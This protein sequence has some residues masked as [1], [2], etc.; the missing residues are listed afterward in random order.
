MILIIN[1]ILMIIIQKIRNK[2]KKVKRKKVS[3]NKIKK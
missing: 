3:L 2:I 1:K